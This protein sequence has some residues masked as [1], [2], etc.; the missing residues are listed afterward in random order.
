MRH[1]AYMVKLSKL[2]SLRDFRISE[3]RTLLNCV[4]PSILRKTLFLDACTCDR[5]LSVMTISENGDKNYFEN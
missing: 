1:S 4:T 2:R 3:L 5:T